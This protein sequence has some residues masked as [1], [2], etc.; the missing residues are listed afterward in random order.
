MFLINCIGFKR[1]TQFSFVISSYEY[2]SILLVA[3]QVS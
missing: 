2:E 3:A 1:K